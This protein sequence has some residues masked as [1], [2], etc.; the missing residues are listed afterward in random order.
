MKRARDDLTDSQNA[1]PGI[2]Q[3]ENNPEK[4]RRYNTQQGLGNMEPL[5]I[6]SMS[7]LINQNPSNMP[8]NPFS[9]N[10]SVAAMEPNFSAVRSVPPPFMISPQRYVFLASIV[11][12]F[13]CSI[14]ITS[15]LF[16][17]HIE[18]AS[19]V[20]PFGTN[21]PSLAQI[22]SLSSVGLQPTQLPPLSQATGGPPLMSPQ[23]LTNPTM[24]VGGKYF[25]ISTIS[26]F[27]LC[28][29]K[30]VPQSAQQAPS[31][32]PQKQNVRYESALDFLDQVKL[33]FAD[34]PK[35]YNQFLDIMKDFKVEIFLRD[36]VFYLK[37]RKL[38][39]LLEL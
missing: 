18:F 5:S 39:I 4:L 20:V 28:S 8:E 17:I 27:C 24:N 1:L 13:F 11:R 32:P 9:G 14:S 33:Q 36:F 38:L 21:Q 7:Q 31:S 15:V 29:S 30:S 10:L 37:R 16:Q 23:F 34:N 19:S 2:S 3:E 6:P 35:V 22:P 12:I 26:F 25:Y